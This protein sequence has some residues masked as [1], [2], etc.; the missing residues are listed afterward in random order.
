MKKHIE[1]VVLMG[2]A[3]GMGNTSP[4]AEWNIQIDPEAAKMVFTSGIAVVQVPLETTHTV[5]VTE[6]ILERINSIEANGSELPQLI[7][8]LLMFFAN[9]YKEQFE[10]ES[11]PLH[12]P[13]TIA[14]LLAPEIFTTRHLNV[15][16]ETSSVLSPGQTVTDYF[17]T[18][19]RLPNATV[20]LKVCR[21]SLPVLSP[22][23]AQ[24]Y[25]TQLL[26]RICSILLYQARQAH[27]LT[28]MQ[29]DVEQF[30]EMM[31]GAVERASIASP[32]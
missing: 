9:T 3:I 23:S 19:G 10:F 2:G 4:C 18:T 29:V 24:T 1:K 28:G 31:I 26:L 16:I 22:T 20:C 7:C 27:L 17:G 25:G 21:Y 6:S 12:D 32:L 5:L 15:E 13:L 14:Y 8:G 30:W 11:P